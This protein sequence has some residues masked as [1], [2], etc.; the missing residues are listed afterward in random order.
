LNLR[1]K[2]YQQISSYITHYVSRML[3]QW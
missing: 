1:K 2:I 3:Q